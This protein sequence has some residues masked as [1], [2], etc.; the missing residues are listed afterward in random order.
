M[1][2]MMKLACIFF[3]LLLLIS[4][5]SRNSDAQGECKGLFPISNSV[6]SKEGEPFPTS[7]EW[8]LVNCRGTVV[9]QPMFLE[10]FE[11][12][13][14]VAVLSN[15][16]ESVLVSEDGKVKRL[17][18]VRVRTPF[19]FGLAIGEVDGKI[20]TIDKQGRLLKYL[21]DADYCY[22]SPCFLSSFFDNGY[23]LVNTTDGARYVSK[24]GGFL[25][26]EDGDNPGPFSDGVAVIEGKNG[27][28][29]IDCSGKV[30]IP[31]NYEEA[32]LEA[33]QG[34]V[35]ASK[36][37]GQTI[38][39]NVQGREVLR[40]NYDYAGRF[41]EGLAGIRIDEKW[42]FMD[43]QGRVSIKPRFDAVREFSEGLAAIQQGLKWGFISKEGSFEIQ[44]SFDL[45]LKPF[46]N[47][48]AYVRNEVFEGYIDRNGRWIWKRPI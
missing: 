40:V 12:A 44:P 35:V 23:A 36:K 32:I 7:Q 3:S 11:F 14:G 9:V 19:A 26:I 37:S 5:S 2:V 17:L 46:K 21:F 10:A 27:F 1:K 39:L 24:D 16:T 47:G 33:S 29:V 41:S 45:V 13:N 34:L 4:M 42:G 48:R 28:G 30:V 38:Y 15:V 43:M 25:K 22:T 8:G 18:G 6:P 31:L 20:Y